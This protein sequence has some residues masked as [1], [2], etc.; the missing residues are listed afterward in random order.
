MLCLARAE[1][2][3]IKPDAMPE[4]APILW[5]DLFRTGEQPDFQMQM[6]VLKKH[7]EPF[8]IL[9]GSAALAAEALS[10]YPAQM[11]KARIAKSALRLALQLRFPVPL[12][13]VNVPISRNDP[14]PRF[15]AGLVGAKPGKFPKLAILAGNPRVQGRRFVILLFDANGRPAM[16]VKTGI[17]ESAAKL[18]RKEIAFLRSAPTGVAGLPTLRSEFAS[19]PVEALALDFVAGNAPTAESR[20]AIGALLGAWLDRSRRVPITE[21]A[22]WQTLAASSTSDSRFQALAARFSN[23]AVSPTIAH[24]DFVPWNIKVSPKDGGWKV[25]DWERGELSGVPGWDW[26]HYVIQTGILVEKLPSADLARKMEG[27]FGDR[28]FQDYAAAAGIKGR[29]NALTAAY[30]FHCVNVVRPAEGREAAER[31]LAIFCERAEG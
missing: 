2:H 7:G 14:L 1:N 9:P 13:R 20:E 23:C 15:L 25:I 4:E 21:L 31:L 17:G 18:I 6:R 29:E 10:L 8:L 24:G 27:L 28:M 5:T 11:G 12:E 3:G 30:L 19:P 16:V 26:L 22:A